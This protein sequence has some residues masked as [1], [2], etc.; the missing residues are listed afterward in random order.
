MIWDLDLCLSISSLLFSE[1]EKVRRRTVQEA[2]KSTTNEWMTAP[3]ITVKLFSCCEQVVSLETTLRPELIPGYQAWTSVPELPLS[4]WEN[5]INTFQKSN[6][7]HLFK[8]CIRSQDSYFGARSINSQKSWS[9]TKVIPRHKKWLPDCIYSDE[10]GPFHWEPILWSHGAQKQQADWV[11]ILNYCIGACQPM[12]FLLKIGRKEYFSETPIYLFLVLPCIYYFL[13][14]EKRDWVASKQSSDNRKTQ[15]LEQ[16][17]TGLKARA[18][19]YKILISIKV[20]SPARAVWQA[21]MDEIS[22]NFVNFR[23]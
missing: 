15:L 5:L 1:S 8:I 11:S 17:C 16:H 4:R 2:S 22:P 7:Y 21:K 13:F 10:E 23:A 9:E 3:F 6:S 20:M 18:S 19:F 12:I 14:L